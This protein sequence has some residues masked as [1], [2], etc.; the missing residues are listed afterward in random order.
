MEMT[1]FF[2]D[3]LKQRRKELG[4]TQNQLAFRISCSLIYLRKLES[5]E[6]RPSEQMVDHLIKVFNI[7][8][9]DRSR[10]LRFARGDIQA[11]GGDFKGKDLHQLGMSSHQNI[12][13]PPTALIGR[14]QDLSD[15]RQYLRNE[16]I[17]LVTLIGPPGIGKTRLGLEVARQSVSDF[18]DG[19]YF[20]EL[21]ALEKSSQIAPSIF[22]TLGYVES[23]SQFVI[24]QLTEGIGDK[25]MLVM[26][27]NLE[28]LVE[29]SALVVSL[30]LSACPQ[31]KIITTSRESLRVPGE[32]LYTVPV[33]IFPTSA[34]PLDPED[35]SRFSAVAL[36]VERA[37]AVNTSFSLN[38][39]NAQA[40]T[41]ICAQL[42][43]VPLAIELI[44][45]RIRLFS[46]QML[47]KQLNEHFILSADG[48]R[49]AS[50]RQKTL[51][52]AIQW[53]YNLLSPD[54]QEL[55]IDL[56]VFS[57]FTISAVNDMC[58]G[59][60]LAKPPIDIVISLLDRSLIHRLPDTDD[61][62][63]F[64]MLMMIRQFAMERL[65]SSGREAEIRDRHLMY[66]LDIAEEADEEIHGPNQIEW[67]E[68]IER[69]HANFQIA[70]EWS[71][72]TQKTEAALRLL[73]ALGWTWWI[74]GHYSETRAWFNQIRNLPGLADHPS[75]Y[76]KLLNRMG[77]Q[78]WELAQDQ[79]D[80]VLL[81]ESR[82]LW[83][84][85]GEAGETGLADC[86]NWLGVVTL[87]NGIAGVTE[88]TTLIR[89][90]LALYQKHGDLVG[91]AQAMLNIGSVNRIKDNTLEWYEKSLELFRKA[92]DIWGMSQVYQGMGREQLEQGNF[93]KAGWCFERQ[94]SMNNS[95]N[96]VAGLMSGIRDLGN[97]ALYKGEYSTAK[98]FYEQSLAVN[99]AHGL[100]PDRYIFF[101]MGILALCQ[102]DYPLALQ[103]FLDMFQIVERS[104]DINIVRDLLAGLSATAA[105]MHNYERAAKLY[106]A[107]QG[108]AET[109]GFRYLSFYE[110]EFG[111]HLKMAKDRLGDPAF[112][113]LVMEGRLMTVEQALAYALA[114][115]SE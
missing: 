28:H 12:P 30:L 44:A 34:A 53:S 67:M 61:E 106:G 59:K 2:G 36:F 82:M 21:A 45:S 32:W 111:R 95:L 25:R 63:C 39:D 22:Q 49:A 76:A 113:R 103:K 69:E 16:R 47:L 18:P 58:A 57:G 1:T 107:F 72:S 89:K 109:T 65:R 105:G 3:W 98:E 88:A 9:V 114:T 68:R 75:Q 91:S 74:R 13:T 70:L 35:I 54:E 42:D 20:V 90:S 7:S 37:R 71:V 80:L 29:D 78:S 10:F 64:G 92:G 87:D 17:R 40:V 6:R 101:Y 8:E 85:L 102:N 79:D 23:K 14:D 100:K 62:N 51:H 31:L 27:D 81:E 19:V 43:G 73:G 41:S 66:L 112:E 11:L 5:G 15:I 108:S 26:L 60:R 93:D 52:N 94:L 33:L 99:R 48:M 24:E 97:L 83:E 38:R 104:H 110:A 96:Y 55:L 84:S 46:P 115:K 56:C 86:L 77:Y 50:A 4:F